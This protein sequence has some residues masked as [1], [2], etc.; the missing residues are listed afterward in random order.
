[1]VGDARGTRRDANRGRRSD[2][3]DA[4]TGDKDSVIVKMVGR[5][6]R[7]DRGVLD[8]ERRTP[9]GSR[10]RPARE[11]DDDERPARDAARSTCSI[12]GWSFQLRI[13]RV[14]VM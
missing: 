12:H 14:L 3:R 5:V 7:D 4:V 8:G 10:S 2:P 1:M 9:I 11:R 6:H 13:G